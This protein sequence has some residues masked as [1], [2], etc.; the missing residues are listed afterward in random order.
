MVVM[1]ELE[2]IEM[3]ETV[4]SVFMLFEFIAGYCL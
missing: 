2:D 4:R 3:I 1:T